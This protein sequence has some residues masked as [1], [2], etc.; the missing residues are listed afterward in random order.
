MKQPHVVTYPISDIVEW[1]ER[2]Q[3]ILT[4]KFQ[5]RGVWPALAKSYLIDTIVRS[6]P[7]PPI[8]IRPLIDVTTKKTAREVV[9]GQQRLQ[10]ILDYIDGK[11]TVLPVHNKNLAQL[12]FSRLPESTKRAILEYKIT[13][14]LLES[15]SDAEVLEVFSRINAYMVP[16]NPQELRNSTY[17]GPFKQAM[18]RIAHRHYQF[19]KLNK[20]LTDEAIARMHDVELVSEITLGILQGP[21]QTDS[22]TIDTFYALYDDYFPLYEHIDEMFAEGFTI[23]AE[24]FDGRLAHTQFRRVP[25]FY[26]FFLL[27]LESLY[28]L[29]DKTALA[30]TGNIKKK[31]DRQLVE[32]LKRVVVEVEHNFLAKPQPTDSGW[33]AFKSAIDRATANTKSRSA[34]DHYLRSLLG[35]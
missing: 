11:F 5:R 4:P 22:K 6:L 7:I 1:H 8:F 20:I 13:T 24:V 17:L 28:D 18:Y 30:T 3:L 10:T 15:I 23:M 21:T 19:F 32:K 9:D 14:N 33:R 16:L 25:L 2:N 31:I 29:S 34:R 27:T 12:P 35:R 26:S